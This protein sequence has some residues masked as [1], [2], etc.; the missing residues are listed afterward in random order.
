M[1]VDIAS[2]ERIDVKAS[3][4]E[5]QQSIEGHQQITAYSQERLDVFE[6][7]MAVD[8]MSTAD[9]Q[10]GTDVDQRRAADR[11]G[12]MYDDSEKIAGQQ[13]NLEGNQQ[14]TADC[15]RSNTIKQLCTESSLAKDIGDMSNVDIL[16]DIVGDFG[17]HL[18]KSFLHRR[19][20]LDQRHLSKECLQQSTGTYQEHTDD[21]QM[22]CAGEQHTNESNLQSSI[23]RQQCT[24]HNQ[25]SSGGIL[26]TSTFNEM[27]DYDGQK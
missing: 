11:H 9:S 1:T 5:R 16:Q 21:D 25:M 22:S 13:H 15:Q 8:R 27:Y 3:I 7:R 12:K 23:G 10:K 18:G 26:P 24:A 17:N 2:Q 14:R 4:A 6:G 20:L 19:R